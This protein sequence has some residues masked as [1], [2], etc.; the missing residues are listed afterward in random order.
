MTP[1]QLARLR[2]RN[3][4]MMAAL[5]CPLC[6]PLLDAFCGTHV[7]ELHEASK[8]TIRAKKGSR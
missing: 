7:L 1:L 3:T 4:V 5:K 8:V 6:R 2:A